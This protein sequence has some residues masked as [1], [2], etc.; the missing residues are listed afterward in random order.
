MVKRFL[1]FLKSVEDKVLATHYYKCI[2]CSAA[3]YKPFKTGFCCPK[4]Q[5]EYLE[6]FNKFFG[7]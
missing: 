5:H 3:S 1:E 7:E 6:K 2:N 4:C